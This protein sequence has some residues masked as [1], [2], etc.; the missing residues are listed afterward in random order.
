MTS[1][2]QSL[3]DQIDQLDATIQNLISERARC[4]QHVAEIKKAEGSTDTVCC[5]AWQNRR[6]VCDGAAAF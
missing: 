5:H 4:A 3:R 1:S 2:L 6:I